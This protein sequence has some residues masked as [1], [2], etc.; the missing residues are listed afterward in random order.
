MVPLYF[1]LVGCLSL[2]VNRGV[3]ALIVLALWA[4]SVWVA[5]LSVFILL[6][7]WRGLLQARVLARAARAPR[8]EGFAQDDVAPIARRAPHLCVISSR[9][10]V[11]DDVETTTATAQGRD[12]RRIDVGWG[13]RVDVDV[14]LGPLRCQLPG[15]HVHASLARAIRRVARG[16]GERAPR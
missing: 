11:P 5:V 9:M 6:N 2:P 8:H 4:R 1:A 14:V 7:C 13:D 12:D 3:A 15:Q 10:E 16:K